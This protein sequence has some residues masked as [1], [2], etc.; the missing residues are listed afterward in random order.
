MPLDIMWRLEVRAAWSVIGYGLK[1]H[2]LFGRR[3]VAGGSNKAPSHFYPAISTVRRC[4]D[5]QAA[6]AAV[7]AILTFTTFRLI[8]CRLSDDACVERIIS[9][10]RQYHRVQHY[11]QFPVH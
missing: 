5:Q 8:L 6:E 1:Q 9:C 3:R 7:F 11:P 4:D 10:H 2:T